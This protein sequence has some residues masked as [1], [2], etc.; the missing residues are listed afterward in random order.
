MVEIPVSH[1]RLS[2][3]KRYGGNVAEFCNETRYYLFGSTSVSFEFQKWVIWE[4]PH[5]Q[6]LLPDKIVMIS[7]ISAYVILESFIIMDSTL[8]TY[9]GVTVVT[10]RP[11]WQ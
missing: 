9:S 1:N 5:R 2:V 8:E 4:D 6:L 7:F 11:Q 10:I 3:F